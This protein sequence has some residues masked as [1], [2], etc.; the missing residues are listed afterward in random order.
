MKYS[1]SPFKLEKNYAKALSDKIEI[2][3]EKTK[4]KGQVFLTLVSPFGLAPG[5]WNDDII[6][7]VVDLNEIW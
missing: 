1:E 2:F 5:L 3:K 7:S 4:F 6:D